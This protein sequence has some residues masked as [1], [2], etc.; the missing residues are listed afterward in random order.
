MVPALRALTPP[1]MSVPASSI[2]VVCLEPI[3]AGH[4]L[5]D[6]LGVLVQVDRHRLVSPCSQALRELGGLVGR[7]VHGV[8]QGDQ[9]VVGLVEDPPTLLDVV[10]VEADD[11]RLGRLVAEDLQRADDAVGDLVARGDAAEDVHEHALDLLV[12]EDH[13]EAVGHHL[14]VGAATD[15]EEVGGLDAAVRLTG[16]RDDVERRHDQARAVADDAD[17]AVELDVVEALRL[18]LRLERVGGFLVLELRVV[19]VAEL[20]VL[21]ERDLAVERLELVAGEPGQRVDLDEGGVL[22][23]EDLPQRQDGLDGLVGSSAGNPASATI[24][25]GLRLVDAGARVDRDLLDGVRVGL[26]DLLDLDT[27]LDAGD[28]EVLAVGAV[29]QEGEV[30][31]LLDARGRRDQHPVDGQ[32]LDLHPE[33]GLGVRL[34]LVGGLGQLDAAG[35]AAAAGLHLR[36]DDAD[37]E[38]LGGGARLR[39]RGRDDARRARHVHAWRRAPS[40]G[41]PSGPRSTQSS[42]VLTVR[43]FLS[44]P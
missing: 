23:D 27:A 19:R 1:T 5:D 33:D 35:L 41:T 25:A 24:V 32:A 37:A 34:G 13:V 22:L 26:R 4:A 17:L 21:V 36:L 31:L 40:P 38:L 9:R 18:G 29:E 14:G 28:A 44:A 16:V 43:G 7:A 39:G 2:R 42:S 20:G 8:D 15:V 10:A 12:V 30:V 6:D 3:A 11:Q